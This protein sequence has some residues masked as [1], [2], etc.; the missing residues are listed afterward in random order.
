MPQKERYWLRS[1]SSFL[2]IN[3]C[4]G[5]N[6]STIGLAREKSGNRGLVPTMLL[7]NRRL[8]KSPWG[9]WRS[10]FKPLFCE[11]FASRH[12]KLRF[13]LWIPLISDPTILL[14]NPSCLRLLQ[15][16][17]GDVLIYLLH[18]P[19]ITTKERMAVGGWALGCFQFR[20]IHSAIWFT[21]NECIISWTTDSFWFPYQ[22]G[23]VTH[24]NLVGHLV[25]WIKRN[26]KASNGI[27]RHHSFEWSNECRLHSLT[28]LIQESKRIRL[29][30][31]H[32]SLNWKQLTP[33]PNCTNW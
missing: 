8:A 24:V 18:L 25:G 5:R 15:A 4:I 32:F 23:A 21:M 31:E 3:R 19:S 17:I 7:D 28:Y 12:P 20:I 16:F 9:Q 26:Q 27:K 10:A 13:P 1:T 22:Y 14:C 6:S 33:M 29:L 30:S 11:C 2:I